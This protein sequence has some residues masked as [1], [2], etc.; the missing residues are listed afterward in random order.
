MVDIKELAVKAAIEDAVIEV[1][2]A[3]VAEVI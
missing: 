2:K 1:I 3:A